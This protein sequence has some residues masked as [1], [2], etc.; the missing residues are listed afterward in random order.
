MPLQSGSDRVLQGDAPL[1]PQRQVPRHPRPGPRRRSPTRRSRTDIIVGFPGETEEDFEETLRV[2]RASRFASAFTFQYSIRP[3]TPAATMADQVP[4]AVV[5]E[6][7]ERLL[8]VQEQVSWAENRRLEGRDGRGARRHRARGARTPPPHRLSGPRPR[9]PARALRGA[10]RAATV[11][12]SRRRG[13]GRR[14]LRRAAPPRRRLR[15][16][17]RGLLRCAAPAAATPGQPC[18]TRPSPGD[19]PSP[20]ACR[21]SGGR[22]RCPRRPLACG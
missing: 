3:G 21:R 9:Q 12:A 10:R 11:P 7:Y 16:R 8:A 5:Q 17:G 6:R 1:L 4:K 22:R 19:P 2:V 13:H 20:S 18:R 15:P 14:H